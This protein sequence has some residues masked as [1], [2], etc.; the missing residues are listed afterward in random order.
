MQ[1]GAPLHRSASGIGVGDG[2]RNM[3]ACA[4]AGAGEQ[5]TELFEGETKSRRCGEN[6]GGG[7]KRQVLP[8][9]VERCNGQ[10]D[11][12]SDGGKQRVMNH[13]ETEHPERMM[14]QHCPVG[15]NEQETRT[16]ERSEEHEDAE[17]PDLVGIDLKLARG[18]KCEHEGEQDSQLRQLHRRKG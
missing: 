5:R 16:D 14:A 4:V 12:R 13:R 8:E 3:R 9:C 6:V 17:I 2:P 10:R 11:E 15:D 18:V 7:T 1:S